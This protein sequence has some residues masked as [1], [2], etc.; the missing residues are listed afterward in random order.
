MIRYLNSMTEAVKATD[1]TLLGRLLETLKN[2]RAKSRSLYVCGN[3]GSHAVALHWGVDLLKV[4][5]IDVHTLGT[6]AAL[7]S[8]LSNDLEYGLML[9]EELIARVRPGD[10]L[11]AMSCSGVSNNIKEVLQSATRIHMRSYLLTGANPSDHPG[12]HIL[13]VQSRDYGVL[14]DVF[15]AIGHHLTRELIQ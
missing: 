1:W 14:E 12:T 15:S 13:R 3:G 11:V 9:S 2:V 10:V 5:H 6:N 7:S 4:A 8:A